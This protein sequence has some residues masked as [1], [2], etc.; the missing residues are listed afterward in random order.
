MISEP[1]WEGE[2][3]AGHTMEVMD[4]S[5]RERGTGGRRPWPWALGGAV[6]ASVLWAAAWYAYGVEDRP[7]DLRGYRL[8]D[9]LCAD[10]P[11]KSIGAAIAPRRTTAEAESWTSR[12]EALDRIRC[13][14]PLESRPAGE[15][16]TG[17]WS[18]E[19]TVSVTVELHKKTDPG[20]EFEARNRDTGPG[21]EEEPRPESVPDLGDTAFLRT[22]DD[23]GT[24]LTV[25][26]GGAVLT[27]YVSSYISYQDDDG[28]GETDEGE[29]DVPETA[30]YRS[31]LISDMRGL[32]A[33][34]KR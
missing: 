31:A 27:L 33:E 22:S 24:E 1:E 25:R 2:S 11:L 19:Y 6:M 17:R 10:L 30:P 32:M 14:V 28:D 15:R 12:H 16:A 5:D 18:V 23:Y 21:A 29:P 7:P 3:G 8:V 26:D 13:G 34:L 9:D 20:P 4:H